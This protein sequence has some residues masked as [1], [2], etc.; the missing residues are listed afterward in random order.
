M[1]PSCAGPSCTDKWLMN[2]TGSSFCSFWLFATVPALGKYFPIT[3]LSGLFPWD[4]R[5]LLQLFWPWG[6]SSMTKRKT[7]FPI[8]IFYFWMYLRNENQSNQFPHLY[9]DSK[10][11][12]IWFLT[13]GKRRDYVFKNNCFTW[14]LFLNGQNISTGIISEGGKLFSIKVSKVKFNTNALLEKA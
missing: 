1:S 2:C 8:I 12:S 5:V 10:C 6:N 14:D 13:G 7:Y 3:G 11:Y 4:H 9:P